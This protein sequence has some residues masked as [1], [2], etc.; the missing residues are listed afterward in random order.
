MKKLMIIFGAVAVCGAIFASNV[1]AIGTFTVTNNTGSQIIVTQSDDNNLVNPYDTTT[2]MYFGDNDGQN[3]II[4]AGT[5]STIICYTGAQINSPDD[6]IFG[7]CNANGMHIY[8]TAMIQVGINNTINQMNKLMITQT[9]GTPT[10][11]GNSSSTSISTNPNGG[12]G[13][14]ISNPTT[15]FKLFK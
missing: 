12:F 9:N 10:I 6:I 14:T 15:G 11:N 7:F 1:N 5:T 3:D 2:Q 4:P 13:L 8:G